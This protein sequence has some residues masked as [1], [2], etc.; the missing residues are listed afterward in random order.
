MAT[1]PAR[2]TTMKY[3]ANRHTVTAMIAGIAVSEL[4]SQSMRP[5]PNGDRS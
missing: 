4:V 3:G 5:K 1:S 2:K